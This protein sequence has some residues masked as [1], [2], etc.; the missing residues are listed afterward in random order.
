MSHQRPTL[1]LLSGGRETPRARAG[2]DDVPTEAATAP[3]PI[4][5]R[6]REAVFRRFA[7][8][9]ARIGL[10]LLGR[11]D[12]VDDLIQDVFLAAQAGLDGL[13]EPE[14]VKGWLAT[15]T[16]RKA[17]RRLGR[18]RFLRTLGLDGSTDYSEV[19]DPAADPTTRRTLADVY[20]VLD[21]VPTEDRVA[22]CLRYVEGER[23]EEV[24][25]LCGC[26]LATVKR[27]IGAAHG[28]ILTELDADG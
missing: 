25:R 12:E 6:D 16:V 18:R 10:R 13:R 3:A 2:A 26:S 20:A 9:V 17:K 11:H 24:A 23:L 7:P 8:Y 21:R 4:D 27:R 14:A 1:R 22:W 19:A 15:V 28:R 5:V